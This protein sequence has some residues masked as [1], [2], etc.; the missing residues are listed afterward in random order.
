M[1]LE[2]FAF[3]HLQFL[4]PFHSFLWRCYE[5]KTGI[6]CWGLWFISK[7]G[8]PW[9][10]YSNFL[11]SWSCSSPSNFHACLKGQ[12]SYLWS[13]LWIVN[14]WPQILKYIDIFVYFTAVV[15]AAVKANG[16]KSNWAIPKQSMGTGWVDNEQKLGQ[17]SK[18]KLSLLV[19]QNV[20][21]I[22][23]QPHWPC[24]FCDFAY[25]S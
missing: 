17:L 13:S 3:G 10:G 4:I 2:N 14:L 22:L 20:I 16:C 24:K 8:L 23:S 6:W 7:D 12:F 5:L 19:N 1:F 9:G 15:P 18:V 11:C 21:F 25:T